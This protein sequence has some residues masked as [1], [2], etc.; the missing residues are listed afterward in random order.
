[1]IYLTEVDE[2]DAVILQVAAGQM[3]PDVF[4]QWVR[5]RIVARP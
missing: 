2:Q 4:T 1:M 3:K 5:S